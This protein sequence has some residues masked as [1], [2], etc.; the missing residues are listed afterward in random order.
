MYFLMFFVAI[1]AGLLAFGGAILGII[2]Y[3]RQAALAE[4]LAR[5][6]ALVAAPTM[7]APAPIAPVTAAPLPIPDMPPLPP[8]AQTPA[9]GGPAGGMRWLEELAGGRLSVLLGGLALALGGV[10]LV[11]YTIEQ[12]LLGPAG[13]ILLGAVFSAALAG[14]GEYLRRGD[15][16]A[17]RVAPA[18]AYVPGALTGAAIVS[19][20]AT[21]YAAYALYSFVGPTFAFILLAACALA[22]LALSSIHGPGLAA[23]GLLGSYATPL[24]IQTDR[25]NAWLLF[26]YLLIVTFACFFTA[27]LRRWLWLAIGA[28]VAADAWV[29]LWILGGGVQQPWAQAFYVTGL[30]SLAVLLL[31]RNQSGNDAGTPPDWP[32]SWLLAGHGTAVTLVAFGDQLSAPSFWAVIAVSLVL[33]WAGWS[34]RSLALAPAIGGI[35]TVLAYIGARNPLEPLLNGAVASPSDTPSGLLWTGA[36]LGA[37]YGAGSAAAFFSRRSNA[38][39]PCLAA[40]VPLA[41]FIYS[42]WFATWAHSSANFALLG[43][44]LAIAYAVAA[45]NTLKSPV[46]AL[47]DWGTAIFAAAA[48]SALA[49]ALAM[50][51]EKGWLTVALAAMAPGLAL[52]EQRRPVPVLRWLVAA[53][54]G[55]VAL[56]LL[57]EPSILGG[58]PGTTPLFNWLLYAYGLPAAAFWYAG[59]E[60]L[61]RRD[62][63]PVK[64]AEGA[65]LM[66]LAGLI[67]TEIRHLMTG[68]SVTG[69]IA[70]LGEFGLHTLSWLGL[71]IGLRLRGGG[72]AGRLV[73][74]YGALLSG[75]LGSASMLVN[76]LL[77]HNPVVTGTPVGGGALFNDLILAY[78][79]PAV[80]AG[81]LYRLMKSASPWWLRTVPATAGLIT[82]FAYFTLETARWFEGSVVSMSHLDPGELYAL[83]VVW[84]LFAL[85]LLTA[86]IRFGN[87]ILRQAAFGVLLLVTLKVFLVDLAGLT[88]LLQAGS[89]IGL[90]LALIGI[91]LAYQRLVLRA[92]KPP[93]QA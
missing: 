58:S 5:L 64:L 19:A 55:L 27:H 46:S 17:G 79:L 38:V 26:G 42:Y 72:D 35:A 29:V 43:V 93:P 56:R 71:S 15:L 3:L 39:W 86:G 14:G 59:R 20:F 41:I 57:T 88:G 12:G 47:T 7:P 69:G 10:F 77:L 4:R 25:P 68:G 60:L 37:G 13:R 84:L 70:S 67:G 40:A 48:V 63:L 23:L 49:L 9:E 45:E 73:P 6:E 44:G 62:D 53:L 31:H 87:A 33:G 81:V 92:A 65:S 2:A 82:A 28:S 52:I 76:T 30:V 36:L 24:L 34:F 89:F 32:L 90:G 1:F 85:G 22:G 54:A 83:S 61:K 21:I 18:N 74:R 50:V 16:S 91:G 11:R 66:F 51:L 8:R 78:L 75:G 80:L